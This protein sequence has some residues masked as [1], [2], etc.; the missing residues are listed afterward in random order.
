MTSS[1]SGILCPWCNVQTIDTSTPRI[2]ANSGICRTRACPTCRRQFD[3]VEVI[4][5]V[6]AATLKEAMAYLN[7][8]YPTICALLRV[9]A[10]RG[11]TVAGEWRIQQSDL[12]AAK[13][14]Y[15][16]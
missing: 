2:V 6:Y 8:D 10:I 15:G 14:K 4:T 13:L 11:Q 16:K 1:A 9:G 3:T 7:I 12:E 5:S